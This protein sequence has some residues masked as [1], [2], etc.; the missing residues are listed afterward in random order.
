MNIQIDIGR[1]RINIIMLCCLFLVIDFHFL[2]IL[3]CLFPLR[4]P[5]SVCSLVISLSLRVLRYKRA[6]IG[7]SRGNK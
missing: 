3:F 5:L 2:F 1:T 4:M 6:R 7:S